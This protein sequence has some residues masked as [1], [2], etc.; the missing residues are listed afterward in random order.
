MKQRIE[1][2]VLLGIA[3]VSGVAGFGLDPKIAGLVI[4]ALHVVLAFCVGLR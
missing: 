2:S 4:A 3:F 1:E